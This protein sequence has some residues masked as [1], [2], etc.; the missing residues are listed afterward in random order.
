[1]AASCAV[2]LPGSAAYAVDIP[3]CLSA[4]SS[5]AGNQSVVVQNTSRHWAWS[6]GWSAVAP[7]PAADMDPVIDPVSEDPIV[8]PET[9]GPIVDP[10]V[11]GP[12]VDPVGNDFGGWLDRLLT[13]TPYQRTVG[14]AQDALDRAQQRIE[15]AQEQADDAVRSASECARQVSEGVYGAPYWSW[16]PSARTWVDFAPPVPV[17]DPSWTW[18]MLDTGVDVRASQGWFDLS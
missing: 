6:R 7:D 3:D 10:E 2:L 15:E 14:R 5:T 13:G 18:S 12:A 8:D 11:E 9:E 4:T 17:G 16:W 1:M